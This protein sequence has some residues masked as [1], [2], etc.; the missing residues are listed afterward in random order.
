MNVVRK[1]VN[2]DY[3]FGQGRNNLI[4]GLP[5]LLQQCKTKLRQLKGEWFLNGDDGAAWFDVIG[6]SVNYDLLNQIIETC[7]M[8]ISGVISIS[9]ITSSFDSATRQLSVYVK[10]TTTYGETDFNELI[11]L[12]VL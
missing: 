1:L 2:N 3:S 7:L 5:A 8:T 10:I 9:G 12:E 4:S 11:G 6:Q